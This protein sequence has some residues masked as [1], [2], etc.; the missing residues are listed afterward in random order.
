MKIPKLQSAVSALLPKAQF[1]ATIPAD[2]VISIG[3]AKQSSYLSGNEF[4][5]VAAQVDMEI[6]TLPEDVLVRVV[7]GDNQ[8]VDGAENEV[9]FRQGAPVPTIHAATLKKDAKTPV[10][11]AVQQG[12]HIDYVENKDASDLKEIVARLHGGVRENTDK[13]HTIESSS[14]HL[15]L[16]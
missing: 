7:D 1:L 12:D 2:E 10:K 8:A 15:H 3:C 6:T 4:D 9:L 14:I 11:L 5:D 13:S 16:N